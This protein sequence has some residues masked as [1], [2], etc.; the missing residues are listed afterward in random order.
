M[1][2]NARRH[3]LN[4]LAAVCRA[5]VNL[6]S[7]NVAL[8][9]VEELDGDADRRSH[10]GQRLRGV[11]EVGGMV[12]GWVGGRLLCDDIDSCAVKRCRS[13]KAA[14]RAQPGNRSYAAA[15]AALPMQGWGPAV[16]GLEVLYLS[17]IT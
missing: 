8:S 1:L 15:L 16:V 17:T 13:S 11:D 7:H 9:L 5:A 12:G 4:Q 6:Q 2:W 14:F 10:G 3:T